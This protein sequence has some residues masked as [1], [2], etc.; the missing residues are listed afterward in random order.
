MA[1]VPDDPEIIFTG[2]DWPALMH[3]VEL[4]RLQ[5]DQDDDYDD[6]Q[7]RR[8]AYLASRFRGTALEWYA[9][10]RATNTALMN[11][12]DTFVQTV[13]NH[14][15]ITDAAVS[16]RNK[17]ELEN[18]RMTADLPAFFGRFETLTLRLALTNDA[19]RIELLRPKILMKYKE[20]IA[21]SGLD[22]V[23]Y[24]S[25]KDR[26]ST[27]WAMDPHRTTAI[28]EPSTSANAKKKKSKCGKCGK[29][30]HTAGECRSK[31]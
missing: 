14:F 11:D 8:C 13:R 28:G 19:T 16:L 7:P 4:S 1:P 26:I 10:E 29:R 17:L 27:M 5:F 15:G 2:E 3:L 30:G 21:S 6:N 20:A 18:L 24:P 9:N 23:T 25:L 12:F 22:Y 31:N